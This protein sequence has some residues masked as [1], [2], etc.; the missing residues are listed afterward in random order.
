MFCCMFW[1]TT[2]SM[3]GL[4]EYFHSKMLNLVPTSVGRDIYSLP[5]QPISWKI[6]SLQWKRWLIPKGNE[7]PEDLSCGFAGCCEFVMLQTSDRTCPSIAWDQISEDDRFHLTSMELR[8]NA[9][10]ILL[11]WF[12]RAF[13]T[14][15]TNRPYSLP[16]LCILLR[17]SQTRKSFSRL[18]SALEGITIAWFPS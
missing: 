1:E 13:L 10:I 7:C 4:L 18:L 11:T 9:V 12:C 8:L 14:I 15:I 3:W 5:Q 2:Q 6:S 17:L 16:F